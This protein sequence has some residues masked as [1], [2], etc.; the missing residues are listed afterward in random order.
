VISSTGT[1]LKSPVQRCVHSQREKCWTPQDFIVAQLEVPRLL[2]GRNNG[3]Y[4]VSSLHSIK[5]FSSAS[6]IFFTHLFS[7][8]CVSSTREDPKFYLWPSN[9]LPFS[10]FPKEKISCLPGFIF[11]SSWSNV[12]MG[13]HKLP[14]S[15]MCAL[16]VFF[17][18]PSKFSKTPRFLSI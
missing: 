12:P 14:K 6:V 13:G 4:N 10:Y 5:I 17:S 16:F 18:D 2:N 11:F 15:S 1:S 9:F 3:P 7:I 8:S